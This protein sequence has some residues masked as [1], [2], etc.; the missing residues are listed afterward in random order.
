[1]QKKTNTLITHGLHINHNEISNAKNIWWLV[2][3]LGTVVSVFLGFL[4]LAINYRTDPII[5]QVKANQSEILSIK[6]NDTRLERK[7][8][9]LLLHF[10]PNAV[11]SG[12]EYLIIK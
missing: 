2:V 8:D 1:M 9:L 5:Q 12:G 11:T 4:N 10:I 7:V 6:S 3:V